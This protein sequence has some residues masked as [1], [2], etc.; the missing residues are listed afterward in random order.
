MDGGAGRRPC[1]MPPA[2][3]NA[4]SRAMYLMSGASSGA[5]S[6][7]VVEILDLVIKTIGSPC[8]RCTVAVYLVFGASG[9]IGSALVEALGRG[10]AGG[11]A[12]VVLAGLHQ[13]KLEATAEKATAG[14]GKGGQQQG[15]CE[16]VT[17]DALEPEE[18]RDWVYTVGRL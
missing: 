3:R 5:G 9:G 6:T 1:R 11:G 2:S 18:V 17:C 14:A 10:A 15:Q 13:D 7:L 8:F 4:V 12:R 16:V